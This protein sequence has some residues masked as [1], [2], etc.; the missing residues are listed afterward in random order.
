MP[1]I[2]NVRLES[3]EKL[4]LEIFRRPVLASRVP[5]TAALYLVNASVLIISKAIGDR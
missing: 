5:P 2:V 3:L 1:P 4:A